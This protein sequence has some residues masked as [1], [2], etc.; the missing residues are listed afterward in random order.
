M[1]EICLMY[2]DRSSTPVETI[3]LISEEDNNESNHSDSD[4]ISNLPMNIIIERD[5]RFMLAVMRNYRV[6]EVLNLISDIRTSGREQFETNELRQIMAEKL[7][8]LNG[9]E[10]ITKYLN[11]LQEQKLETSEIYL[12]ILT[13]TTDLVACSLELSIV[14]NSCNLFELIKTQM[15]VLKKKY[16]FDKRVRLCNNFYIWYW[17]IIIC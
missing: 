14:L 12:F 6:K 3:R 8:E 16:L 5:L 17:S 7:V 11:F 9:G 1:P 4:K 15:Q 2:L 10:I 13:K